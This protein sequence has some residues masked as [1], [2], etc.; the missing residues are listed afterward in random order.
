MRDL[1]VIREKLS[2]RL[3]GG[4]P[5]T[6]IVP[7][8]TGF[9]N[10]TYVV[11][12]PD[13]ILR[14]PPAGGAML[15]GRGV[16]DQARIYQELAESAGAP[17]VPQIVDL[18]DDPGVIGVPFF[19]MARVSGDA[20]HDIQ[21]Q[22]WFTDIADAER[23]RM[24]EDWVSTIGGLARLQPLKVLGPVLSPENDMRK[25]SAFAAAADCPAVVNA[26]ARLLKVP[27][28]RSGPPAVVHGDP[29]LSNLMWQNGRI[30]ALLDWEMALNGEPLSDLAYM[31]YGFES[32]FH[33]ATRAQKLPG[34]LS[35][36]DAILLWSKVSGRPVEGL[37]WHEIAQ[38]AKLCAILAEGVNMLRTGR[39]TD[40][41]LAWFQQNLDNWIS[42]TNAM[43]DAG[44]F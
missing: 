21:M 2:A 34:M 19:V 37:L 9:S 25:W 4:A 18:C 8:T 41:K 23:T 10:E 42:V 22:P 6:G 32:A 14:L 38:F 20:I 28:P 1:N 16:I 44:G 40:P 36:D 27:A 11:E 7:M 17:T 24:C 26:I 43:L 39:S 29:K 30:T 12:G 31:L 15:E 33:P 5:I 35:R 3:P 13:L